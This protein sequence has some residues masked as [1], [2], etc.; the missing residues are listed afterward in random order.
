MPKNYPVGIGMNPSKTELGSFI[1]ARRLEAGLGQIQFAQL[2]KIGQAQLSNIERGNQKYLNDEQVKN[3]AKAIR[4]SSKELKKRIPVKK[5]AQKTELGILVRSRRQELGMTIEDLAEKV[6]ITPDYLL[7]LERKRILRKIHY[8]TAQR[9][10]TALVLDPVLFADFIGKPKKTSNSALGQLLR[11]RRR[12]FA[13]AQREVGKR[14]GITKQYLSMI[15]L[16]KI[17]LSSSDNL[18]QQL[19]DILELDIHDLHAVRPKRRLKELSAPRGGLGKFIS[20]RRLALRLTQAQLAQRA[21]INSATV[22][23]IE[24]GRQYPFR[25]MREKLSTA[26]EC[27][28]PP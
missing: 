10:A 22:S 17:P 3:F 8:K 12:E 16:G 28:L 23:Q 15:E 2:L 6:K 27:E 9:L 21:G 4:C 19:A 24:R 20:D 11:S 13:M 26:L 25:T 14:I 5:A 1:R 18:I 7:V